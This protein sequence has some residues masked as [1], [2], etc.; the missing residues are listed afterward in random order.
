MP[1]SVALLPVIE[2]P[3]ATVDVVIFGIVEE[4]LCVLLVRR[5]N[6]PAEPF[7]GRWALPGGF[8]D[9][10]AD[11]SIEACALRKLRE[12][13]GVRSPYLEQLGSWGGATRDP[14]GWSVTNV[15]F[16]LIDTQRARLTAGGNVDEVAWRAIDGEGVTDRLAFDHGT[17][18]AAAVQ[19]LRNKVEYTSLPAFLLPATFTLRELQTIYEIVLGRALDKSAFRTRMLGAD[20][21]EGTGERRMG[22]NRPAEV[23]RLKEREAVFFSRTFRGGE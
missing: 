16:A 7:P 20:F 6:G 10:G 15:Y 22:A 9:V 13:T 1:L 2:R 17:L 21:I 18:L 19:R 3:L 23:Y 8:I 12:K 5:P 14:R 4:R 11:A